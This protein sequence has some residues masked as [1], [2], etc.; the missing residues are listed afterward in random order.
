MGVLCT[1]ARQHV[2]TSAHQQDFGPDEAGAK[3]ESDHH[4][5]ERVLLAGMCVVH[6]A[7]C[8]VHASDCGVHTRGCVVHV[9]TTAGFRGLKIDSLVAYAPAKRV[10]NRVDCGLW[11]RGERERERERQ[12][13]TSPYERWHSRVTASRVESNVGIQGSQH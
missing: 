11:V 2:S 4:P 5:L 8:G 9:S 7:E 1:S 3:S 10:T 12:E 13:V 6:A